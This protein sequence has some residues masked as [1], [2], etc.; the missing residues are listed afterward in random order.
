MIAIPEYHQTCWTYHNSRSRNGRHGTYIGLHFED[1][2]PV[3]TKS[4]ET[5]PGPAW[6]KWWA[7]ANTFPTY[8]VRFNDIHTP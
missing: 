4:G 7:Y 2:V 3:F 5:L 6:D 8:I 1:D